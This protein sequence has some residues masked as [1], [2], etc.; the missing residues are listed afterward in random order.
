MIR[1]HET[2]RVPH[3]WQGQDKALVIQLERVL[4][5]LYRIFSNLDESVVTN[6][7]YD[8]QT[9]KLTVTIN[10]IT[11]DV[12]SV[13]T[14]D[15]N[16]KIPAS[17]LPSYVDDLEE[18]DTLSDFPATGEA[19]K[20]YVARDTGFT[21][22]WSGTQYVR[23]NT[24]DE[25][26]QLNSGLMS[27]SDKTKLDGIENGA[28]NYS[29]PLSANGTRGGIQTGYTETGQKYAVKLSGEQAF[30]EVPWQDT[31]NSAGTMNR[32]NK[33]LFLVGAE[34]QA[35]NPTTNSNANVYIGTDNCLYSNGTKVLTSHQ[36]ISGKADKATTV[37]SV[38]Y[39]SG[40][41]K[42]TKTINGTATDVVTVA[43]IK[44]AL[45]SFT[46]GALAGQ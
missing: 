14:L 42:I 33:K 2:L 6:V 7:T 35:T 18:Y 31:K 4:N 17:Q 29:L 23:L 19:D 32:V 16:G 15:G 20:I 10:G 11:E 45:G 21:Y 22:R 37:T 27:A 34:T 30:V 44:S 28:N 26:T 3:G 12:V 25:A 41:K 43:T 1:Q 9:Q 8:A 24:Y 5:D 39:D 40:N 38:D 46:W 36:D 13:A